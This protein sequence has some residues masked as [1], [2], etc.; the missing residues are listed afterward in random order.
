MALDARYLSAAIPGPWML[1]N[2]TA[3]SR[4]FRS[5]LLPISYWYKNLVPVWLIFRFVKEFFTIW[6]IGIVWFFYFGLVL[7]LF[8][9]EVGEVRR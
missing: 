5:S 3:R 2:R 8:D 7:C 9:G 4:Y 6:L 1:R